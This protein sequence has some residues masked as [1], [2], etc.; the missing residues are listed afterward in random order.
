MLFEKVTQLT[1][2][3]YYFFL[4]LCNWPT[5]LGVISA[6][7]KFGKLL[8]QVLFGPDSLRGPNQWY[9][10]TDAPIVDMVTLDNASDYWTNGLL[11][12]RDN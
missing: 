7:Q 10:S 3:G 9:P 12:Y 6:G 4:F 5:F 11:D 8:W 1:C 2:Y